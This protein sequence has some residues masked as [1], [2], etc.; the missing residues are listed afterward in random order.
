[1]SALTRQH[2]GEL[3]DV[4]MTTQIH[5]FGSKKHSIICSFLKSRASQRGTIIHGGG[6]TGILG[7]GIVE[8]DPLEGE[9]FVMLG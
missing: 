7:T 9:I 6:H 8:P 3:R 4:L 1:M 2:R 5:D